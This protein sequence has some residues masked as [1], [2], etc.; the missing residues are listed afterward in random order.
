MNRVI[1]RKENHKKNGRQILGTTSKNKNLIKT[2]TISNKQN[3]QSRYSVKNKKNITKPTINTT[4]KNLES[5]LNREGV[6]IE[7]LI[8]GTSGLTVN[9]DTTIEGGLTVN[10]DATID[11]NI[12]INNITTD[13]IDAVDGNFENLTSIN[14]AT[15]NGAITS[16]PISGNDIANK[17]YVDSVAGGGVASLT[18]AGTGES[19]V[20]DSTGVL[21]A[22]AAPASEIEVNTFGTEPTANILLNLADTGVSAG[23]YTNANITVDAKG[24]LTSATNG[25]AASSVYGY[26]NIN[27]PISMPAGTPEATLTYS[28][29]SVGGDITHSA[30]TFTINTT[31][32]YRFFYQTKLFEN[33]ALSG[34][35]QVFMRIRNG[36]T[37]IGTRMILAADIPEQTLNIDD[38]TILSTT[39]DITTVPANITFTL[40]NDYVSGEL[41]QNTDLATYVLI[42]K[43]D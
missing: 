15:I 17:T 40:V 14:F 24:R 21:K 30:G 3:G 25:S 6:F 27:A 11:G 8:V 41:G 38:I 9:G 26:G 13:S 36:G 39:V 16:A 34:T 5:N 31:G 37:A 23:S 12:T 1:I 10:G 2:D 33:I 28:S 43:I 22:I 18:S 29:T 42:Q 19:L 35:G 7:E 4:T 32:L 20:N